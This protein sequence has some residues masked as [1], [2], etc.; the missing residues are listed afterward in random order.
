MQKTKKNWALRLMV[1]V[2]AF[3]LIS[4]CLVGSALAKYV[5]T[6]SGSDTA[7]VAKWGVTVSATNS[8]LFSWT[9]VKHSTSHPTLTTNSVIAANGVDNVVA[10]GTSGTAGGFSVTGTPE[11]ACEVKIVIDKTN[12]KIENWTVAAGAVYEP[13]IWSLNGTMVGT[14]GTFAELLAELSDTVIICPAGTDLSTLGLGLGISWSWPFYVSGTN[15]TNDTY[16]GNK[17]AGTVAGGIPTITLV[18]DVVVTQID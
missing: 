10:P 13:I 3:T 16:L 6:S 4:T 9:Y 18:Y 2:L 11:V 5:T 14:S 7:R 1:L 12:S 15:D 17:A 8:G